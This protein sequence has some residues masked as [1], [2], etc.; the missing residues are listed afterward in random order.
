MY[1]IDNYDFN[2]D[3]YRPEDDDVLEVDCCNH[4][5]RFRSSHMT[6]RENARDAAERWDLR[7]TLYNFYQFCISG[8]A[9]DPLYPHEKFKAVFDK[10][11]W[12][13]FNGMAYDAEPLETLKKMVMYLFDTDPDCNSWLSILPDLDWP[14]CDLFDKYHKTAVDALLFL[15]NNPE[16]QILP[17]QKPFIPYLRSVYDEIYNAIGLYELPE[18]AYWCCALSIATARGC[19]DNSWWDNLERMSRSDLYEYLRRKP[20]DASIFSEETKNMMME[21]VELAIRYMEPFAETM[22]Q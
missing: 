1:D 10:A 7:G 14:P 2:P 8:Y 18:T 17:L 21:I 3:T 9:N 16:T 22:N 15:N 20:V 5:E 19:L 4:F 12:I 13:D 6:F 11:A